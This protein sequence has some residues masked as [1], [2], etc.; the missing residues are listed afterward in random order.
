VRSC[1]S[2]TSVVESGTCAWNSECPLGR[3]AEMSTT[4]LGDEFHVDRQVRR[5]CSGLMF[6]ELRLGLGL[7]TGA[8]F[9]GTAGIRRAEGN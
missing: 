5:W 2:K 4:M 1:D 7:G 9:G 8:D 3:W 6:R